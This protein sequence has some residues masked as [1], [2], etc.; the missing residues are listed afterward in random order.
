MT[1]LRS[2]ILRITEDCDLNCAYCYADA[3]PGGAHMK[4][5]TACRAIELACPPGGSLR[6]QF[7]GGEPLLAWETITAAA[8]FGRRTGRRLSMSVQTNGILLTPERCRALLALPC[9]VG[10]SLDGP[11]ALNG[12]RRFPDGA[13]SYE[14][15]AAGI[16]RL[17]E[18]GGRCNLTAVVTALNAPRLELLADLALTL[19]NVRGVGLDLFRPLGRG[20]GAD[21]APDPASLRR[22]LRALVE[23]TLTLERAGVP[24]HLRELDRWRS[25]R[26]S[27]GGEFY[28][29]AQTELSLAVDARGDLWPCSSLAGRKE[30]RL[31]NL[32]DGLPAGERG[33]AA[34]EAPAECR[35]CG[36]FFLCGGGCP[37]GR[38][39]GRPAPL[40]CV[41]QAVIS[42]IMTGDES[43]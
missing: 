18:A 39:A 1:E 25:R 14:E 37:A 35:R 32:R 42:E 12:C 30:F 2:L 10:V 33:L 23:K 17:G 36:R 19:G 24:F 9:A 38:T 4:P 31:G 40:T 8:D 6:V 11:G 15:A 41:M 22:G 26:K 13:P 29:Y 7:T 21:L 28:C 5:E 20:A 27:G 3:G 34:L 43:L 16:R